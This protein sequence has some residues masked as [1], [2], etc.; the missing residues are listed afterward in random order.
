MSNKIRKWE[1]D[2]NNYKD[3]KIDEIIKNMKVEA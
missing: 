2:Y 1:R 3:G